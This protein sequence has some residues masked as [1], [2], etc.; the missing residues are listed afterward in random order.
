M[1]SVEIHAVLND[2]C[3]RVSRLEKDRVRT[4]RGHTNQIGAASYL[5]KSREWL[6]QRE[7]RGDGPRRNPDGSYSYDDLDAFSETRTA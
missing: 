6:R 5:G 7:R 2:L 1:P 3:Q 4:K